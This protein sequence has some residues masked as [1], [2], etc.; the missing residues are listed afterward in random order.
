MR[1]RES[2]LLHVCPSFRSRHPSPSLSPPL[3]LPFK[4][5]GSVQLPSLCRELT[6]SST[7]TCACAL[8]CVDP[9][10]ITKSANGDREKT[11]G[12]SLDYDAQAYVCG[13]KTTQ[14]NDERRRTTCEWEW[15]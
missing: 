4:S 3:L 6:L 1:E 8:V 12:D 13:S 2:V 5:E 9:L 14:V 7:Q 10:S 11:R 15:G